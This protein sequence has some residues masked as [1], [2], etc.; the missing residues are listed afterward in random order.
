MA[1]RKTVNKRRVSR[2]AKSGDGKSSQYANKLVQ[3]KQ[4]RFHKD[5]PYTLVEGGEGLSLTEFNKR[6]SKP[7]ENV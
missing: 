5:S 7:A 3:A 1:K 6:R 4:G 2:G